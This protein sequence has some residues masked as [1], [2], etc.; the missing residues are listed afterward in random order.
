MEVSGYLHA[1]A[2][3]SALEPHFTE[4]WLA[5]RSVWK[6]WIREFVARVWQ[7]AT[8]RRVTKQATYTKTVSKLHLVPGYRKMGYCFVRVC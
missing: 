6:L 1:L 8:S 3:T 7:R 5:V 4:G 2:A